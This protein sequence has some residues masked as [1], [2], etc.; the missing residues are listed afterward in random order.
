MDERGEVILQR[1]FER[2]QSGETWLAV[3]LGASPYPCVSGPSHEVRVCSESSRFPYYNHSVFSLQ[4][5]E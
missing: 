2:E 1:A 5:Q 4:E 3:E